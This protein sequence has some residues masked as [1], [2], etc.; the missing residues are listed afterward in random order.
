MYNETLTIANKDGKLITK[1][2]IRSPCPKQRILQIDNEVNRQ[3][4]FEETKVVHT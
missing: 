2:K 3:S 4:A 1:N